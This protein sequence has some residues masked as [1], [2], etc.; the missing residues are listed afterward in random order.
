MAEVPP[1]PLRPSMC[2][3]VE[4]WR[5]LDDNRMMGAMVGTIP[6]DA[7]QNSKLGLPMLYLDTTKA[8]T[9]PLHRRDVVARHLAGRGLW[10]G[11]QP[12]YGCDLVVYLKDPRK[13]HSDWLVH[14]VE[15]GKGPTPRELVLWRRVAEGVR[16]ACVVAVVEKDEV[17]GYWT[18]VRG[19]PRERQEDA[20][21]DEDDVTA[22]ATSDGGLQL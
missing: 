13:C 10:V 2:H 17:K 6:S 22:A 21:E 8:A 1:L 18:I 3:T 19:D 4:G 16:K 9:G 11:A 5:K 20:E 7:Q 15:A 12:N 14:V